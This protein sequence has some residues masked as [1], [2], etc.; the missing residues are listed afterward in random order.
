LIT[1]DHNY[2]VLPCGTAHGHPY[3][4]LADKKIKGNRELSADFSSVS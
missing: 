4:L 1:I 2:I 3:L